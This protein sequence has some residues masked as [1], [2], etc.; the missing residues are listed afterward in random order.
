MKNA[1]EAKTTKV[2]TT[3]AKSTGKKK[4]SI[5]GTKLFRK[6]VSMTG[7]PVLIVS[8]VLTIV[9]GISLSSALSDRTIDS[10]KAV[11]ATT[12]ATLKSMDSRDYYMNENGIVFKGDYQITDNNQIFLNI[13]NRARMDITFYYK[14][15]S[16]ATSIG[17]PKSDAYLTGEEAAETLVK[18]VLETGA[19]KSY[20]NFMQQGNATYA[21]C[22]PISNTMGETVGM[23]LVTMDKAETVAYIYKRV[24]FSV[25]CGLIMSLVAVFIGIIT[26]RRMVRPILENKRLIDQLAEGRLDAE[27]TQ[28]GDKKKSGSS[29]EIGQMGR[30]VEGLQ[31]QL[32]AVITEMKG[33][34]NRLLQNGA[35]LGE[36][37]T[38]ADATTGDIGVAVREVSESS[39]NQAS[40]IADALASIGEIGNLVD[41]IVDSVEKL[42]VT[43][44][45]MEA[46]QNVSKTN[47]ARLS[48]TNDNTLAAIAQ[49]G[50]QIK[51]T[52]DSI[53]SINEAVDMISSIADQTTL[54][55]LNASIEAARAGEA[56]KG[57]AVVAGEIQKL[58]TESNDSATRI[59]QNISEVVAN[60]TNTMNDMNNMQ[61]ILDEQ[62][63]CLEETIT[64][65]EQFAEGVIATTEEAKSIKGFAAECDRAREATEKNMNTLAAISQ[66]NASGAQE[67][68]ASMDT[69]VET[70]GRVADSSQDLEKVAKEVS[71]SLDFFKL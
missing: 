30:A 16:V 22:A 60:S 67:T 33:V 70:V 43:A 20:D 45:Q 21:Y 37:A 28:K 59:K 27:V 13:K 34:S 62:I 32:T 26:S 65:F 2:K 3:K 54:L 71:T 55:S 25:A 14:N 12:Q 38:K 40:E 19:E 46:A 7:I 69:L 64:Q 31:R 23:L 36:I 24:A 1:E 6:F 49:M 8:I 61:K 50:D 51:K 53:E 42:N 58:A 52:N 4:N 15:I 68:T 63:S 44:S 35:S 47:F 17:D 41:S 9:A 10:L 56:G 39:N 29:D 48:E 18:N 57:F 11:A 66:Q 5:V